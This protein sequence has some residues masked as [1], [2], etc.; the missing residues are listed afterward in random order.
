MALINCSECGREISDQIKACPHCGY[1]VKRRGSMMKGKVGRKIIIFVGILLLLAIIAIIAA[2][3]L[4]NPANKFVSCL[5][6]NDIE[7]AVEIYNND[8]KDDSKDVK[9]ANNKLKQNIEAIVKDYV[10]E[11]QNYDYTIEKLNEY[12][13]FK[14]VSSQRK[15][16]VEAVEELKASRLAYEK[17]IECLNNKDNESAVS[18]FKNVI[19]SDANYSDAQKKISELSVIVAEDYSVSAEESF[20]NKKYNAAMLDIRR[21]ILLQ[22]E[23]STYNE[24]LD[25]YTKAKKKADEKEK[26][27]EEKAKKLTKGKIIEKDTVEVEYRGYQITTKLLP[28]DTSGYYSYYQADD[29]EIF[30][31]F[32]FKV[33]NNGKYDLN[34]NSLVSNVKADYDGGFLYDNYS[35]YYISDG[36]IEYV[37]DWDYLE[38]LKSATFHLAVRV[39]RKIADTEKSLIVSFDICN[40]EQKIQIR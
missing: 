6:E 10:D 36:D 37:F 32:I 23:N 13:V 16:A 40:K 24:L 28:T 1:P 5:N 30:L 2:L 15:E 35:C 4:N 21:A 18:V 29:D 31:D 33:S 39:P 14:S 8:L 20:K 34:L 22:P 25:K 12:K 9:N 3:Y 11:V 27:A 38:P 17:G 7:R 19:E 26:R